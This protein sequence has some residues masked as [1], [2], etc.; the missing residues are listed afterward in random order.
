[1]MFESLEKRCLLSVAGSHFVPGAY[2][3]VQAVQVG[4]L[5]TLNNAHDVFVFEGAPGQVSVS[6]KSVG[7]SVIVPVVYV[8]VTTL[9]INGTKGGDIISTGN[10]FMSVTINAGAGSDSIVVADNQSGSTVV[11][12]GGGN[13]TILV[14]KF[15]A[16][17]RVFGETGRDTYTGP[18]GVFVQ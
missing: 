16:G 13:D 2:G 6:D 11:H 9:V 3:P 8:G 5:L 4:S 10:D 12:A 1:M 18:A 14:G 15:N 17:T 7:G